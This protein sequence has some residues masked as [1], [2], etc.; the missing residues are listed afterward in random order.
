MAIG[1][2]NEIEDA[3]NMTVQQRLLD[4]AEELFSDHGFAGTSVRDIA[5]AADCNV[6][7]VNYYFRGKDNLYH[8]VW[9]RQLLRMRDERLDSINK[10]MSRNEGEPKL[11]DLLRSFA[12]A[13]IGPLVNETKARCLMK[14]MAREMI[15]QHLPENVFV[16][17]IIRPTMAAMREA[18]AKVCPTLHESKVPLVVFSL[19]GQL[20]H[21]VR[22]RTMFEHTDNAEMPM[23]NLSE[24]VNHIIRFSAA[25]IRA[26]AKGDNE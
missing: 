13:F 10:V 16:E 7:A 14:L 24:A 21:A 1:R 17:E 4:A 12:H 26:Y 3:S 25:G 15:D 22:V 2:D 8:K 5:A 23:L 20:I 18:L 6:A 9:R 11:E 19:V